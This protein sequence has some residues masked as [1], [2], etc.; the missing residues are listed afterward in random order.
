MGA[1]D[2][3]FERAVEEFISG[4]LIA[5]EEVAGS[6]PVA[7]PE[8]APAP[9]SGTGE[10]DGARSSLSRFSRRKA[11]SDIYE[12]RGL[13]PTPG[14]P[15]APLE[16]AESAVEDAPQRAGEADVPDE[17]PDAVP[18]PALLQADAL[19]AAAEAGDP[20]TR[21]RRARARFLASF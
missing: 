16:V 4:G 12:I 21:Q 14:G 19:S 13:G 20:E 2:D 8:P 3:E 7:L 17:V 11:D 18:A 15:G 1:I 9:A 5:G 10:A 6:E